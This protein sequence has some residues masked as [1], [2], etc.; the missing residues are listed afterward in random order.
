MMVSAE[1]DPRRTGTIWALNLDEPMPDIAPLIPATFCRAGPEFL[2]VL[3]ETMDR[4]ET[5]IR[6]RFES[7]RRCYTAWVEGKLAAYG[8]LSFEEEYIGELNL[9]LRLL[10]GEAYI[11]DCVTM[12]AFRQQRLY[13]GLL[14]YIVAEL[15]A[16]KLCRVWIGADLE[17]LPSQRGIARAGFRPVADMVVARVLAMRLVWVQGRPGVPESLIAEAR[18]AFLDNRDK[19]WLS[20]LSSIEQS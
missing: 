5:E 17:N 12:P 11:W 2:P 6:K 4:D 8:W 7:G 1:N 16:E 20:V 9:R 19:V 13:S 10:S 15:G 3:T 18:R 14:R